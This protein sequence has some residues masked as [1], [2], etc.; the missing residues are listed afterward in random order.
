MPKVRKYLEKAGD[1]IDLAPIISRYSTSVRA[2]YK[3]LW[4]KIEEKM[5][6]ERVE[7]DAHVAELMAFGEEVFLAPDW[8]RNGS[9][10][11]R[12]GTVR[13]GAAARWPRFARSD[14]RSG[15]G[16]SVESLWTTKVLR[17]SVITRGHRSICVFPSSRAAQT[18]SPRC[19]ASRGAS[20]GRVAPAVLS[21]P[22]PSLGIR[23]GHLPLFRRSRNVHR[24]FYTG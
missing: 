22:P 5:K 24:C 9:K 4:L 17:K 11:R 12:T 15:T 14:L 20:L 19:S 2:F 18:S 8:F 3:W 21:A 6:P 13:G 7:Y 23:A 1:S 10:P 16:R